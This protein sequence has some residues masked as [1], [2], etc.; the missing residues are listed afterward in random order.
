MTDPVAFF[1]CQFRRQ[2][3]SEEFILNLALEAGRRGCDVLA[4]DASLTAVARRV[5]AKLQ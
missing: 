1:D 3:E 4:V 5:A 2:V